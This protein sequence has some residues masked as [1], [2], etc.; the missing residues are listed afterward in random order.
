MTLRARR[1]RRKVP[2]EED[3]IFFNLRAILDSRQPQTQKE[4]EQNLRTTGAFVAF[5]AT[6]ALCIAFYVNFRAY[7]LAL[8]KLDSLTTLFHNPNARVASGDQ[9]KR[10][11][12][13]LGV[14]NEAEQQ[15]E[16]QTQ[17]NDTLQTVTQ[18][19][20]AAKQPSV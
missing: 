17:L 1:E 8:E 9:G 11:L 15:Q 16:K 14:S 5:I 19:L 2:Q 13:K 6:G 18:L 12:K 4:F 7:H 10:I 3:G 20:Q